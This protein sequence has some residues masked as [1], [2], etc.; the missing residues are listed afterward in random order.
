MW[1]HYLCKRSN[2]IC[3]PNNSPFPQACGIQLR[4][5]CMDPK[6]AAWLLDPGAKEMNLHRM[7]TN[8]LPLHVHL[9]DG[10]STN[11]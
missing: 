10:M 4:S 8:G 7:V 2:A 6:V 5:A 11:T 3:K 9:L 1:V